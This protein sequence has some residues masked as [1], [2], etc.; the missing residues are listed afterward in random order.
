[1][2][3]GGILVPIGSFGPQGGRAQPTGGGGSGLWVI[4]LVLFGLG[5][6]LVPPVS[7]VRWAIDGGGALVVGIP[8]VRWAQGML[9]RWDAPLPK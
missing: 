2:G 7:A 5:V 4:P 6:A 9:H 3:K 8:L 1:M